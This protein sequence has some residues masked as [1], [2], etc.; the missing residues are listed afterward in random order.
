MM[1]DMKENRPSPVTPSSFQQL[2][3]HWQQRLTDFSSGLALSGDDVR[4]CTVLQRRCGGGSGSGP[5]RRQQ[6][7]GW[8]QRAQPTACRGVFCLE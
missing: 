1:T 8:C 4:R 2:R 7:K 3:R 6:Q 5:M